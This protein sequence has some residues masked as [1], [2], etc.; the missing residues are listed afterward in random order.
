MKA[1]RL[2]LLLFL[3]ALPALGQNVHVPLDYWGYG[4]LERMEAK[5]LFKSLALLDRPLNRSQVAGLITAIDLRSAQQP[6][7]LT[8]T[9]RRLLE[10]L[11]GD[12]ADE[13]GTMTGAVAPK[14]RELH[15]ARWQEGTS[16][17]YLDLYSSINV[18]SNR[19]GSYQPADLLTEGTLGAILRGHLGGVLG[20]Y[21]DARNA[22]TRGEKS[23]SDQ[24]ENYD[25]SKGS[26]VTV[27][28]P[29]VFRD[30]ALAYFIW[31]KPWLRIQVGRD[32]IDWGPGFHS[33]LALTRNMPPADMIRLSSRFRRVAFSSAHLFLRSPLGAKYLAAHRIDFL[34]KPGL[35][36]GGGETVVY[37]NRDVEMDYLN[38]LMLYHIAEHHLGDR[39]NN[40]LFLDL[41]C[42]PLP[43]TRLYAQYFIDDMTS[44]QS[45]TRYYGNKFALLAGALWSDPL[46]ADNLDLRLEYSRVEPF[47]YAHHDSINIYTHYD[48]VIG[49]W[50]GPNSDSAYLLAGYQLGRDLRLEASFERIRKGEGAAD[51]QARP[52]KGTTKHFLDGLVEKK[53]LTG[54]RIQDQ[55]RRDLFVAL[56]Y[57]YVASRNAGR[58]ADRSAGDHLA[59]FEVAYNY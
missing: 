15:A 13:L 27:S 29:N 32:E 53:C 44:T 8:E 22:V 56:A 12:F 50:L 54:F 48:K 39:D 46:G 41:S 51:T 40:T 6:N 37:G 57:T 33:G 5:G 30:R 10:Q 59:R 18:I 43:G 21:A 2:S 3:C 11:R 34:I 9:D 16:Q 31:E 23:V 17:A 52:G 25:V 28:G 38:P 20:F 47:V 19:G 1:R 58:V 45:L 7:L 42:T 36:F 4:F 35:Q 24:D 14:R 26:P 49:H 55:L